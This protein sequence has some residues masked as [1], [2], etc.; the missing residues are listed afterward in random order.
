MS[1]VEPSP[2]QRTDIVPEEINAAKFATLLRAESST[3][4]DDRECC[5]DCHSIA[6]VKHSP[7][8]VGDRS[9]SAYRCDKCGLGFDEPERKGGV[10]E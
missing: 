10:D 5:P 2:G 3:P 6:I 7:G 8:I 4:T 9:K 1:G